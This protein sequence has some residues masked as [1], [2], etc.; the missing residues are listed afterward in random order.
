M[1][2]LEI[3]Q[4]FDGMVLD[5]LQEKDL[6]D[7]AIM[8]ML[9]KDFSKLKFELAIYLY[10]NSKPHRI[11]ADVG[12]YLGYGDAHAINKILCGRTS[13]KKAKEN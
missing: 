3:I 10:K 9:P 8:R 12:E 5:F 6:I 2:T 1:L 7:T 13:K 4:Q 11:Q